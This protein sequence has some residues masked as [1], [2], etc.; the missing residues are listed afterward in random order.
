MTD[1]EERLLDD[2]RR[3]A[4]GLGETP[5]SRQMDERGWRGS[6]TYRRHFGSWNTALREAGLEPIMEMGIS[7]E[8]LLDEIRRLHDELGRVP[9]S[10]MMAEYG[11][12]NPETYRRKLGGWAASVRKAGFTPANQNDLT[13][14]DLLA[15]IRSVAGELGKSPTCEEFTNH[16]TCNDATVM[17]RF[18][19]WEAALVEAGLTTGEWRYIPNLG[20]SIEGLRTVIYHGYENAFPDAAQ[21]VRDD[22]NGVCEWCE[23]AVDLLHAHHIIPA[24]ADGSN[25]EEMLMALCV[26]CHARADLYTARHLV[27]YSALPRLVNS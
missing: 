9:T 23:E 21:S 12:Y 3:V 17:N 24:L 26:S 4:D 1:Y 20:G 11:K 14:D 8:E 13:N 19:S 16:S 18:G 22:A 25:S 7:G 15:E 6:G 5:S 27:E 10:D 2:L